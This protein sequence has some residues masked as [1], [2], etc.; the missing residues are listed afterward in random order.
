[1]SLWE[2]FGGKINFYLPKFHLV[3][4]ILGRFALIRTLGQC[5]YHDAVVMNALMRDLGTSGGAF[6]KR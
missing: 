6:N 4:S 1:M 2:A 3:T 5:G